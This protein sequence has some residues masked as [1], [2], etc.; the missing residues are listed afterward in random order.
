[1]RQTNKLDYWGRCVEVAPPYRK[2]HTWI[3]VIARVHGFLSITDR[4]DSTF[5]GIC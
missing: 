2:C 3:P 5:H 1:M 4:I